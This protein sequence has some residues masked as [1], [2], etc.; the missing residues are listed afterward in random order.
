MTNTA[1]GWIAAISVALLWGTEGSLATLPLSLIDAKL[2]V[3]LR[4]VIAFSLLGIVLAVS[5]FRGDSHI[6]RPKVFCFSWQNRKDVLKLFLCGVVGQGLFS[7]LS[8][9][10]LDYITISENGVIQGLLPIATLLV[11]ALCHGDRFTLVQMGAAIVSLLGVILLV[12]S[13]SGHQPGVN[14]GHFICLFSVLSFASVTHFRVQ[15]AKQYGGVQ[16]MLYQFG[17]A[18]LGF[19]FYLLSDGADFN[20]LHLLFTP[21]HELLCVLILGTCVSGFGYLG[22][23]YGVERVGVD[24]SSMALNLIPM[25]AFLIGTLVFGE[26]VTLLRILAMAM[27]VGGMVLFVKPSPSK[28]QVVYSVNN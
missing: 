3:W 25:S 8:F 4:Y 26:E 11:G 21:A 27:I 22:Y 12:F 16:T 5:P 7:Y 14:I 2:L 24:G 9:L 6:K 28:P 23:I 18:A 13:P 20:N 19:F 15:L 1:K 17:F 10:S